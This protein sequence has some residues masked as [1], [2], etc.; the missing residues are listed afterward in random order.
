MEADRVEIRQPTPAPSSSTAGK[1]LVADDP[2]MAAAKAELEKA[3]KS[4]AARQ[5]LRN[6][7]AQI[8]TLHNKEPGK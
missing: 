6:A 4:K 3:L 8:S 5:R 7:T 2:L 1:H